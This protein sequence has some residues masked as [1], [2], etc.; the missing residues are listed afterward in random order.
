[1][2]RSEAGFTVTEL[3]IVLVIMPLIIGSI[4]AVVVTGLLDQNNVSSRTTDSTSAE[5]T[6]S[7]FIRD[8][9]SAAFVTTNQSATPAPCGYAPSPPPGDPVTSSW[10]F[11]LGLSWGASG[12]DTASSSNVSYSTDGQGDLVRLACSG[13]STS[14]DAA[15]NVATGLTNPGGISVSISPSPSASSA[16][17]GWEAAGAQ[18]PIS[19]VALNGLTAATSYN[20]N[21]VAVPR[22]TTPQNQG[23]VAGAPSS[24]ALLLL[25]G[26]PSLV[27]SAGT[28]NV[29]GNAG[30]NSTSD[31][32][33]VLS[34]SAQ[35][36]VTGQ[37][38]TADS[39]AGG[40]ITASPDSSYTPRPPTYVSGGTADPYS[41]SVAPSPNGMAQD[42]PPVISGN[43]ET[44]SP[45]VYNS[46][47]AV[48]NGYQATLG[49]GKYIIHGNLTVSGDS[50]LT[51]A[52]GG[53]FI[54]IDSG[55][56]VSVSGTA[57]LTLSTLTS[58]S[59]DPG[60]TIWQADSNP[61]TFASSSSSDL[62]G[63]VY[64][65]ASEVV[66]QAGAEITINQLVAQ[67]LQ[68]A[69]NGLTTFG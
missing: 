3:L 54:Y 45:G 21:L 44:F 29:D 38:Y 9:Q 69:S 4:A 68:C 12:P 34:N 42:P 22:I 67:S 56:A 60:V 28:I 33:A 6:S 46:G 23:T 64:A 27:C 20:F 31:G 63:A 48:A 35:L 55:G 26:N 15:V 40:A 2:K 57:E 39:N 10:T 8:V 51:S 49:S 19:A 47:L 37:I 65:P 43:I 13:G 36:N 52:S 25:G 11:L 53:V 61:L 5:L 16:A 62:G 1:M 66:G 50:T 58:G 59:P 41:S 24:P 30:L 7:Y 17:A 18:P 14:S 32:A